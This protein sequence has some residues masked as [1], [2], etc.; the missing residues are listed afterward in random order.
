MCQTES[1]PVVVAASD[2]ML[3]AGDIEF[4]PPQTKAYRVGENAIILVAGDMATQVRVCNDTYASVLEHPTTSIADIADRYAD[5]FALLRQE[6]AERTLL[7]PLGLN[8]GS[9]AKKSTISPELV[10]R[11]TGEL[12][13]YTLDVEAIVAGVDSAGAHIFVITDPGIAVCNDAIGFA[14]VGFGDRH[15]ESQFM[16]ARFTHRWPLSQTLFLTYSAKRRAEV[17]PSVGQQTDL[18]VINAQQTVH[19]LRD[20]IREARTD[21]RERGGKARRSQH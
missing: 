9:F 12:R 20:S 5:S 2:R 13:H 21:L 3:T 14:A 4:E 1:L 10:N 7:T 16:L 8:L 18:H 17:A 6:R 15:A 19:V 11:L